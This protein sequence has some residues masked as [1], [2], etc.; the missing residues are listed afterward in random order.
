MRLMD[1]DVSKGQLSEERKQLHDP[2][3]SE[4]ATLSFEVCES[5]FAALL[6]ETAQMTETP[7]QPPP[8]LCQ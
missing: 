6:V 2:A 5:A 8:H 4:T 1:G 3:R 7:G